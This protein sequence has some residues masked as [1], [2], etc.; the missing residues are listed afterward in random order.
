VSWQDVD[1]AAY[2]LQ[3]VRGKPKIRDN[4]LYFY[5]ENSW[6]FVQSVQFNETSH[7]I[8]D[9]Q[10]Y[11]GVSSHGGALDVRAGRHESEEVANDFNAGVT[12]NSSLGLWVGQA[13]EPAELN[14]AVFGTLSVTIGSTT[15]VC[16]D[17]R[18]GQGHYLTNNNW[19]I[20]GTKC[21][22]ENLPKLGLNCSCGDHPNATNIRFLDRDDGHG[23]DLNVFF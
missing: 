17:I 23:H 18:I 19:W 2:A 8:T 5:D 1:D 15:R 9:E 12:P 6:D 10:P 7:S 22:L 11:D 4:Y 16:Q 20:A 14:F 21:H 3:K 13:H